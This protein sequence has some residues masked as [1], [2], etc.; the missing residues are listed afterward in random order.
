M[1]RG[2]PRN[3]YPIGEVLQK[4]QVRSIRN[5]RAC[6]IRCM[7]VDEAKGVRKDRSRWHSVVSAH[8]HGKKVLVYVCINKM[9]L[10]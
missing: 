1:W 10:Q 9:T 7:N 3:T 6:K 8:P 4:G 2:L 5:R